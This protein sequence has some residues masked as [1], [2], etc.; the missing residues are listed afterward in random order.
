MPREY[1][2]R[3]LEC[4]SSS[5]W[6]WEVQVDA[7]SACSSLEE[8]YISGWKDAVDV[9]IV[10]S[11]NGFR[12]LA[13]ACAAAAALCA[14]AGAAVASSPPPP[15]P[16]GG[17]TPPPPASTSAP[18]TTQ[19]TTQT[20]TS[21]SAS[22]ST[23]TTPP[24]DRRPPAAVS[25][26]HAITTVPGKI[27]LRWSNPPA[28]DLAGIVLRRAWGGACP[29]SPHDGVRVGGTGIRT[30]QVDTGAADNTRYCYAA[31]AFDG[32]GNYSRAALDRRVTN[33]G[34]RTAPGPVTGLAV[35]A[36]ARGQVVVS[37]HNPQRAGIAFDAVRRGVYPSC[38]TG[39]ADGS[40]VGG[41]SVR[42][43]QVDASARPGVTYCYRVF[44]LDAAGN[45]SAAAGGDARLPKP[46]VPHRAPAPGPVAHASRGGLTS[47][48]V[49]AVAI[50]GFL[51]LLVTV[52]ATVKTRRRA[53]STAYL[54]AARGQFAPARQFG[55]RVAMTASG[56]GV[57]VI[58]ALA[59]LGCSVAI[60]LVLLNL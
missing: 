6:G 34:D 39:P 35:T 3:R 53:H 38:P 22:T 29:S 47:T 20:T 43:S 60:A 16:T 13:A 5:L 15:P 17:G 36:N 23:S 21:T 54:P 26:L 59:V 14:G 9:G 40:P 2:R 45:A 42:S 55:P 41:E 33:P 28:S 1:D 7:F 11:V 49:R 32:H 24:P 12:A 50:A 19:T 27:T 10:R 4:A 58:P 52:L 56:P 8:I 31:F 44:A 25:G 37:W 30:A 51:L 57:L 48:L 18:T 46:A